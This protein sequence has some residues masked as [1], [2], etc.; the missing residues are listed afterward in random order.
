MESGPLLFVSDTEMV[1]LYEEL[2]LLD[3]LQTILEDKYK[4]FKIRSQAFVED[5][6]SETARFAQ[7]LNVGNSKI[8]CDKRHIELHQKKEH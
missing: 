3:E 4:Y 6:F 1:N 8:F 2:Y 5:F 7:M